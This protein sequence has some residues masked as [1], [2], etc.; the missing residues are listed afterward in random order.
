MC[1][2]PRMRNESLSVHCQSLDTH[3][4]RGG[5]GLGRAAPPR[6]FT[7]LYRSFSR[8]HMAVACKAC[9]RKRCKHEWPPLAPLPVTIPACGSPST[10]QCFAHSRAPGSEG[11]PCH[12]LGGTKMSGGPVYSALGRIGGQKTALCH[13]QG[14]VPGHGCRTLSHARTRRPE[15]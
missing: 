3:A 10:G 4:H 11:V 9:T 7:S 5:A 8:R 1:I 6:S 14:L 15:R 2:F 12:V 13:K